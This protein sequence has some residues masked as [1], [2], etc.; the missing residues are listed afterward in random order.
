M[1]EGPN[2][3]LAAVEKRLAARGY[4]VIVVAEG[5]G[6]EH[7]GTGL[8]H[9]ASGNT[10]LGDVGLLLKDRIAAQVRVR[11]APAIV[12]YVDPSHII[13]SGAA[14]SN[15]VVF[16][17]FLGQH[18]VHAAMA[19]KT[20][21]V[22]GSWNNRFV[23]IPIEAAVSSHKRVRPQG[24]LWRSVLESTGQPESMVNTS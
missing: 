15:D 20:N 12:R 18:A 22:V 21:V 9:D 23:H 11:G 17:G 2:D 3:L 4:A 19:G 10:A 24:T 13:R 5:A 14:N 7:F 8:G 16:C 6:Q 1:I